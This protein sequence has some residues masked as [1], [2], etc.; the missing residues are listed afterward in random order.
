MILRTQDVAHQRRMCE[1]IP[2]FPLMRLDKDTNE[3]F[4]HAQASG[5]PLEELLAPP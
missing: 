2:R 4:L 3:S 5:V 1:S